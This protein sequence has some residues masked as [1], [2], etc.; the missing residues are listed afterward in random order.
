MNTI[1][2]PLLIAGAIGLS[3]AC[4]AVVFY[5]NFGPNNSY[6]MQVGHLILDDPTIYF[7]QGQSFMS[8]ASGLATTLDI[9]M[10]HVS[11]N[12]GV[13][14]GMFFDVGGS[15]FGQ[16]G[17]LVPLTIPAG[18]FGYANAYQSVNVSAAGWNLT[19][20]T[21]YW[22]VAFPN[23]GSNHGWHFNSTGAAGNHYY[24]GNYNPLVTEGVFRLTAVPEPSTLLIALFVS[25]RGLHRQRRK[26]D[27]K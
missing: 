24:G 15:I 26:R 23:P 21:I 25:G 14:M 13:S 4:P 20:G 10:G 12:T 1:T 17:N 19:A 18:S 6:N 3:M 27:G 9:A 22:L 8:G 2:R 16:L 7:P 11:G 5:N